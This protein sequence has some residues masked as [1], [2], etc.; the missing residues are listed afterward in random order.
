VNKSLEF[1]ERLDYVRGM[2]TC[3]RTTS[4]IIKLTTIKFDVHPATARAYINR[5]HKNWGRA[6]SKK[7]SYYKSKYIE[8][9]E[10]LYSKCY[11]QKRYTNCI[12]A[13]DLLNKMTG[14]YE[15]ETIHTDDQIVINY[16]IV[17]GAAQAPDATLPD[18][19]DSN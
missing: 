6:K 15:A 9:L 3:G 1:K 14:M 12:Q 16:H 4:E 18:P 7:Y 19:Q 2:L 8:R 13:Q 11:E 17:S 10:N 5:A